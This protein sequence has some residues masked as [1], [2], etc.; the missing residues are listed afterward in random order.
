MSRIEDDD[1][2]FLYGDAKDVEEPPK[3]STTGKT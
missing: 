3:L 1:D 2:D